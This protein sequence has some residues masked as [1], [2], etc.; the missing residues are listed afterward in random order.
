MQKLVYVPPGGDFNDAQ[1]RVILTA[2]E[3]F[4]LSTVKGLGGVETN[5]LTS[6]VVGMNGSYYQG[7]RIA[8][9][10]IQCTVYVDGKN[11][12]DMYR[13]RCKLIG[14]LTPTSEL[15]ALYYT[16]DYISVKTSAIPS[17][18]PDFTERIRNYNKAD[19]TFYCPSPDWIALQE[20]HESIAYIDD[21]GFSFPFS[22]QQTISFAMLRNEISI[23]YQ[24]TA[25]APVKITIIG[26]AT[27]PALTNTATGKSIGLLDKELSDGEQLIITTERGNKSVKLFKD[28]TTTDAFQYIDPESEFW[29]LVPGTNRIVYNSDDDSKT[30]VHI[31]YVNR[32]SGV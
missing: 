21:V 5:L 16:N 29:E 8:S 10:Q 32:Y 27:N 1:K 23:A 26:P 25:P 7:N 14:L 6:N 12:E 30:K 17:L 24:G 22:F 4:I 31:D 15:G 28:N 19:I 11:R 2:E 20:Q 9:R 18:P 3:P 13:Q